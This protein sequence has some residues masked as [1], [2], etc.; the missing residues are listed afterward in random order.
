MVLLC[1]HFLP[2]FLVGDGYQVLPWKAT[3]SEMKRWLI[4]QGYGRLVRT[5]KEDAS[6]HHYV[7]G[8]RG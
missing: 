4:A 8:E 3:I 6:K 7:W 5:S 2:I 1:T